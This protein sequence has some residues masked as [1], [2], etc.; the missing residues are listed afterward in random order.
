MT[1]PSARMTGRITIVEYLR[2][3][4]ALS[5]AWFHV[6]NTH[7]HDW[8]RWSGSFG[9]LGVDVFFVISGFVI[10]LS[11]SSTYDRYSIRQFPQFM[12]RRVVRLEPPY[13]IS[14]AL[15]LGLWQ[16][17][18][19]VPGFPGANSFG[20]CRAGSGPFLLPDPLHALRLVTAR[21]LELGW[22][23]AFY[24][25]IGLLFPLIGNP[26]NSVPWYA[27]AALI[28]GLTAAHVL[29]ARAGLFVMGMGVYR[30][31]AFNRLL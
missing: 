3:L 7:P 21:L 29:P 6:T 16:L 18:S 20:G 4:A 22:E 17:S 19:M 11:I 26:D 1:E 9:W 23:F 5:V 8:V 24:I 28:L 14:I 10:P 27:C 15:A 13:L 12:A 30:L 31:V 25:T 2:G